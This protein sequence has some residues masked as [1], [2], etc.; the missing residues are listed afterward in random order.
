M[1]GREGKAGD[2]GRR[3]SQSHSEATLTRPAFP[4]FFLDAIEETYNQDPNSLCLL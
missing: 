2:D 1:A 4:C 3:A